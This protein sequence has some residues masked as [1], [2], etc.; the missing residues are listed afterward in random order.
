VVV[1]GL[2][3]IGVPLV[4]A[5]LPGVITPKPLLNTGI[6]L[7]LDPA[8]IVDGL[9]PKPLISGGGPVL[10]VELPAPQPTKLNMATVAISATITDAAFRFMTASTGVTEFG[11]YGRLNFG[12]IR[13]GS[14]PG[15]R[16]LLAETVANCQRF[17]EGNSRDLA[18][19]MLARGK[20]GDNYKFHS[21]GDHGHNQTAQAFA[22]A[23][24]CRRLFQGRFLHKSRL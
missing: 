23:C 18:L 14:G 10:G 3:L 7:E 2:T 21:V 8:S 5:M 19:C 17:P 1:A 22:V 11:G 12:Q 4:A 16:A 6:K 15:K 13:T 24:S 20:S 9:A